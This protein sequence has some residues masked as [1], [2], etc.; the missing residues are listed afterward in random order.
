MRAAWIIG[1]MLAGAVV[2]T[3]A[4][5]AGLLLWAILNPKKNAELEMGFVVY[6]VLMPVLGLILG[7]TAGGLFAWARP[8]LAPSAGRHFLFFAGPP[9]LAS[10]LLFLSGGWMQVVRDIGQLFGGNSWTDRLHGF[11]NAFFF[12]GPLA[13]ALGLFLCATIILREQ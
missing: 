10:G 3:I 1:C 13:T 4:A 9:V 7:V 2:A 8:D 5:F 12:L 6:F 11:L